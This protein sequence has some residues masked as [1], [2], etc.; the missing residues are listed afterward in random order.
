[1]RHPSM[2]LYIAY[3]LSDISILWMVYCQN[4]T[5]N[6]APHLRAPNHEEPKGGMGEGRGGRGFA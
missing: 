2:W 1:M 5:L 4:T 3:S 6:P